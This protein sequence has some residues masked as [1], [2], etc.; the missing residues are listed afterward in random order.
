[1]TSS[2]CWS[3]GHRLIMAQPKVHGSQLE[4]GEEVRGV[5]FVARGEPPE[6]FDAVEEAL[7]AVAF[8]IEH[9]AEARFPAAMHHWRNVRGGADGLDLPTQPIGVVC[10][11]GEHDS[12]LA[13][14]AE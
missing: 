12:V 10:L 9:R 8:A 5:L 14:M 13:Q 4:H 3:L 6:V 1:M 7:D 11:V 2:S